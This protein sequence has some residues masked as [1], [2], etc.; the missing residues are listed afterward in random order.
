MLEWLVLEP[1]LLKKI[2]SPGLVKNDLLENR[3]FKRRELYGVIDPFHLPLEPALHG[4]EPFYNPVLNFLYPSEH[5]ILLHLEPLRVET[6]MRSRTFPRFD[7][8]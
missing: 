6:E 1:R 5:F 3:S 8:T 4:T 2:V 7:H